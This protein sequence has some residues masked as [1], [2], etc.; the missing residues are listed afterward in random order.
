MN[1]KLNNHDMVSIFQNKQFFFVGNE[2]RNQTIHVFFV[3]INI[4]KNLAGNMKLTVKLSKES[5][6]STNVCLKFRKPVLTLKC[7]RF[8]LFST[9]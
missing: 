3:E 2:N 4:Y 9:C 1:E 5:N 8:W 7:L 6:N